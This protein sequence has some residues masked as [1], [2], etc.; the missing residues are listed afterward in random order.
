MKKFGFAG[1]P[2]CPWFRA[3]QT[4]FPLQYGGT[5]VPSS[6]GEANSTRLAQFIALNLFLNF[7]DEF[8]LNFVIE[9]SWGGNKFGNAMTTDTQLHENTGTRFIA[10]L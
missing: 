1:F 9:K 4:G 2:L 8:C 10:N 7:N 6:R 5:R 3:V